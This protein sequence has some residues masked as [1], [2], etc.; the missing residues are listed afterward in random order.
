LRL[1]AA[2][3]NVLICYYGTAPLGRLVGVASRYTSPAIGFW[4]VLGPLFYLLAIALSPLA[5]VLI[6]RF[7][8]DSAVERVDRPTNGA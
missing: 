7:Q 5:A 8:R 1:L 3:N 6:R 2:G 4:L